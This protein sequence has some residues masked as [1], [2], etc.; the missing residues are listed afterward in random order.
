M[1]SDLELLL[2]GVLEVGAPGV[3][4][5]LCVYGP[6]AFPVVGTLNEVRAPIVAAGHWGNGRIVALGHD[7]YFR[8]ETLDTSDTGQLVKNAL[9]WTSGEATSAPR[10]GIAGDSELCGCLDRAGHDV[11]GVQLARD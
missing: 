7:G 5:P 1:K 11:I 10:I 3:P 6:R 4:G 2:E 8:R 9:C